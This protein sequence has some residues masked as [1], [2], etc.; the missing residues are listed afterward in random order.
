LN[1]QTLETVLARIAQTGVWNEGTAMLRFMSEKAWTRDLWLSLKSRIENITN[2]LSRLYAEG[3]EAV[4]ARAAEDKPFASTPDPR[5]QDTRSRLEAKRE[6][7]TGPLTSGRQDQ[8]E[9]GGDFTPRG[10]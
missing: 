7:M 2:E 4:G 8:A 9:M 5:V 10:N 3:R 1:G 6:T